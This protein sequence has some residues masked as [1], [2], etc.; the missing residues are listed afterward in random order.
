MKE[1]LFLPKTWSLSVIALLLLFFTGWVACPG[2]AATED[3]DFLGNASEFGKECLADTKNILLS[4]R[5]WGR[6]EWAKAAL[7]AGVTLILYQSD[8]EIR[9]SWQQNRD[10]FGDDFFRLIGKTGHVGYLAPALGL[11]Y[12]YAGRSGNSRAREAALAGLESVL[13]AGGLTTVVKLSFR[14]SRPYTEAGP[15]SFD[16]PGL[17][18]DDDRLS[19]CSLHSAAVF[20][21]ATAVAEYYQDQPGTS[22]VVYSVASLAA[23]SRINDDQHWSSDVFCGAVLGHYLAKLVV[24]RR[25]GR[26]EASSIAPLITDDGITLVWRYRF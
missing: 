4:P 16:G 19:F 26:D 5:D 11:W 22:V 13:I 12:L 24:A 14:R 8:Q 21:A 20:A 2:R 6:A 23:L 1:A 9:D 10:D 15:D 17:A 7:A 18:W 3:S 25:K